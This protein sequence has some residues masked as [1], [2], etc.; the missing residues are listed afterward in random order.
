[1]FIRLL[2]KLYICLLIIVNN[3]ANDLISVND[4]YN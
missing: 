2:Y 4:N 3:T 1:M